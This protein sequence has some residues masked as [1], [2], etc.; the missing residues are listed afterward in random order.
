MTIKSKLSLALLMVLFPFSVHLAAAEKTSGIQSFRD[1]EAIT[2][3]HF[4]QRKGFQ[5]KDIITREEGKALF[6]KLSLHGWTVPSAD[7]V[8]DRMLP[9]DSFLVRQFTSQ[10]G[11]SFMRKVNRYPQSYD[12]IDRLSHM[13]QGKQDVHD[14]I[15]KLPDGEQIIIAMSTTKRGHRL[16]DRLG[17]S[18]AGRDFAKPTKRIYTMPDLLA[19]LKQSY[20]STSVLSKSGRKST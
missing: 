7:S 12:Y 1:V 6:K 15:N 13:P 18:R 8:L 19:E 11:Q 14:M 9:K 3:H 17:K 16:I 20:A 10:K 4:Q 5:E 2:K